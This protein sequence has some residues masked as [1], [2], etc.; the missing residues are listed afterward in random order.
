MSRN[1]L[2]EAIV[3]PAQLMGVG[4]D[5]ALLDGLLEDASTLQEETDTREG[6]LPLL[7]VALEDLWQC[8][9]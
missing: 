9:G 2:R 4:Y 7:Q 8:S 1:E 6:I 5:A 3:G